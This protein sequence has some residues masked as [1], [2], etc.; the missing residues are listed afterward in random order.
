MP[1][2]QYLFMT[3]AAL[4]LHFGS[5]LPHTAQ[6]D[7][8]ALSPEQIAAFEATL[9]R[10][11]TSR[12]RLGR[13]SGCLN[14]YLLQQQ[15]ESAERERALAEAMSRR[16]DLQQQLTEIESRLKGYEDLVR[17]EQ[18]A[19]DAKRATLE[20]ARRERDEQAERLK[21]C[22]QVLFFLP[23]ICQAGESAV[24]GFGWMNDAEAEFRAAEPRLRNA[25]HALA[26]I[27]NQLEDHRKQLDGAQQR[28]AEA[29]AAVRQIEAL[30]VRTKAA[31]AVINTKVQDFNI[32][33]TSVSE[34]LK[35]AREVD[36]DDARLRQV[37]RL[38]A[39]LDDLSNKAPSVTAT[40]QADLP[41][42]ARRACP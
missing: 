35:E 39:D 20:K 27:R 8:A 31:I 14:A 13:E 26:D 40:A 5:G 10:A 16:T 37:A 24:K 33:V 1:I 6:A 7:A 9:D 17:S 2:R 38:S 21:T 32:A 29:E 42:D 22:S 25:E 15:A 19:V 34:T 23:G 3:A 18:Q 36:P 41:E 4:A 28:Q 12:E 11:E 30:I